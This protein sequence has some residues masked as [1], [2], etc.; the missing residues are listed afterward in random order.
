MKKEKEAKKLIKS[1]Q[2][3][4][5]VKIIRD[6]NG[7][8]LKES[9]DQCEAWRDEIFPPAPEV[10]DLPKL[11]LEAALEIAAKALDYPAHRLNTP[12]RKPEAQ[13]PVDALCLL[14]AKAQQA[15][16][17]E[18]AINEALRRMGHPNPRP[19]CAPAAACLAAV[20]E[21]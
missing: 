1:H 18:A 13:L 5:A 6:A 7:I 14:H 3:I 2:L 15:A 4:A 16:K 12:S 8:G 20:L 11:K 9:K 17:L 19:A 21:T 10:F